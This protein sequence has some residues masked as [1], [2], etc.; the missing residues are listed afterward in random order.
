[1]MTYKTTI[2]YNRLLAMDGVVFEA[3]LVAIE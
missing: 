2:V 3:M 1:M